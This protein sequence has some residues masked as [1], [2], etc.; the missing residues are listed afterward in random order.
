MTIQPPRKDAARRSL[1]ERTRAA[2]EAQEKAFRKFQQK[3]ARAERLEAA[4]STRARKLDTRKKI[5]VGALAIE[6]MKYD[7]SFAA[8][9]TRILNAYVVKDPERQL[10]GLGPRQDKPSNVA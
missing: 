5:I 3:K 10:L 8:A 7:A 6:H 1:E 4:H 2:R 9:L